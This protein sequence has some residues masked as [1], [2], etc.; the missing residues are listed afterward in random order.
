MYVRGEASRMRQPPIP[1][2]VRV[3]ENDIGI[4]IR[5]PSDLAFVDA[6]LTASKTWL[7][8]Q[9]MAQLRPILVTL[10]EL[11]VNAITHGNESD[12]T[13]Q[14]SC[15]LR[16][17]SSGVRI[18]VEDEGEGFDTDL[19]D[20]SLPGDPK[21]IE[22]RGLIL[23]RAMSKTLVF[24]ASHGRVM[25]YID[26][27]TLPIPDHEFV[28]GETP[29]ASRQSAEEFSRLVEYELGCARRYERDAALV[30]VGSGNGPIHY[31]AVLGGTL[32]FSDCFTELEDC[33]AVLMGETGRDGALNAVDRYKAAVNG[34]TDLRYAVASFPPDGENARSLISAGRE[35]LGLAR[36]GDYGAV[37]WET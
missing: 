12:L 37:V 1:P 21:R 35:R 7:Q 25:A 23:V 22:K 34:G 28:H 26:P 18:C 30:M 24:D 8:G 32:R 3:V 2:E 13:K 29:A 31:G 6:A 9:D 16:A 14:V 15:E 17:T 20:M 36:Q 27:Q 10:R 19:I 4:A 11:A 5:F 33:A